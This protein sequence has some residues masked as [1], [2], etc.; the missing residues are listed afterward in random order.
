MKNKT[1]K[2]FIRFRR[3]WLFSLALFVLV[4]AA[5][6]ILKIQAANVSGWPWGGTEDPGIGGSLGSIDGNETG[7]GWISTSG[8][9][10]GINI[11]GTDGDL[12]GNAW[13]E[14]L[15]WISFNNSDLAGCPSGICSARREGDYLKGWAR[16]LSMPQAGS[17]A[18]GWNG[19]ISLSGSNYG[20]QISKMDGTGNNHTYAWSDELGWIDFSRAKACAT[21]P[22]CATRTLCEGATFSSCDSSFC[23]GSAACTLGSDKIS[24]T[25]SDSC[26]NSLPCA[27]IVIA[28]QDGQCGAAGSE[29]FCG[30]NA[31]AVDLCS[32]GTASSVSTGYAEYT[33]TCGGICGGNQVNCSAPGIHCGWIEANP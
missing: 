7:V 15:G 26:G 5:A 25:C 14:N 18:G 22:G 32:N 19:W 12:S 21:F 1:I 13:S 4:F 33:W 23:T 9:N 20:V 2:K 17:N 11:P 29:N 3:K 24:W 30:K 31:P 8:S 16:I 27:T 10:Y 28:K 6:S